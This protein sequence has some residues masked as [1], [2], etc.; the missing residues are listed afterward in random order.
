MSLGTCASSLSAVAYTPP[1]PVPELP[2][3]DAP[4]THRMPS[5]SLSFV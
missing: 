4:N 5:K 2:P 3:V 1:V